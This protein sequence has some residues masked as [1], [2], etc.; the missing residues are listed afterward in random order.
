[1]EK[2]GVKLSAGRFS[3]RGGAGAML[4]LWRDA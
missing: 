3:D 1:M 2:D 4:R